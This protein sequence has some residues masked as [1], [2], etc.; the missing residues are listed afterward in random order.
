MHNNRES[1]CAVLYTVVAVKKTESEAAE[2][3]A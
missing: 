2:L 1:Q 3:P